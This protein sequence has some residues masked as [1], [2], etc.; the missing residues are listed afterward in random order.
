MKFG[1]DSKRSRHAGSGGR[2]RLAGPAFCVLAVLAAAALLPGPATAIDES[3]LGALKRVESVRIDGNASISTATLKKVIRT[4]SGSFLGLTSLPLYR[5][6]F[7]RADQ[8]AIQ[9]VYARRGFLDASVAAGTDSGS[10]PGRVIVHY[11]VSEGPQ[12]FVRSVTVDST[13]EFTPAELGRNIG[14]NVGRPYDP[15]QVDLDRKALADRYA[16]R[17]YFPTVHTD[18]H[19][20]STVVDVHYMIL[21][22]PRYRVRDIVVS[23]VQEVDTSAVLRELLLQRGDVFRQQLVTRSTERL[24]QTGLFQVAELSPTATDSTT[25]EVDLG[26][27][28]RERRPRWIDGGVGTG[29]FEKVRLSAQWGNRNLEGSG[30]SLT[31]SGSFGYNRADSTD[32]F[33]T[34][35]ALTYGEPWLLGTRTQG[36]VSASYER[37]FD[38]FPTRIYLE[39]ANGLSFGLSRVLAG[40]RSRLSLTL[41]NIWTLE[42]RV[43]RRPGAGDTTAATIPAIDTFKV[44][45]YE[46]RW[47]LAF[48]QDRRDDPL[49]P[50]AGRLTHLSTQLAGSQSGGE[51]RYLKYELLEAALRPA[52]TRG[53]VGARLRAGFIAGL[54][55]GPSGDFGVLARVQPTDRFRVGGASSV[56][57]FRENGIDDGG[58]SGRVMLNLNFEN[59]FPLKGIL[60]GVLFLDGGNVWRSPAEIK[61]ARLVRATGING[62][63]GR[64]D[65]H[66]SVGL[67]LRL[68]TPVGPVRFDYGRRLATDES[69]LGDP[70]PAKG[71]FHLSLG[72]L[73]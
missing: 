28:V 63:F 21:P 56:R 54:G 39:R 47:T 35:E 73:F 69:D 43:L 41:D 48:D 50:R 51:G 44:A 18:V 36:R 29:T 33:R 9:F 46:R 45:P 25:G 67:G 52:W 38:L 31:A 22:G 42:S 1:R 16:D 13:A 5:P 37:G 62:T 19:R 6:D 60:S 55:P 61:P 59:R 17:G 57:G 58:N 11:R 68:R 66:W 72:Q 27:R 7:L 2:F 70:T 30:R 26:V 15:V 20:D 3:L 12:V 65:M 4:G 23:G 24:Y 34:R 8:S 10:A 71:S 64:A 53:A 32:L 14:V 49:D 40:S